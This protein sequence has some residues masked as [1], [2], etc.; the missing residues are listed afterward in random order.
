MSTVFY[1]GMGIDIITPLVCV[2][3]VNKIVATGPL[4]H[5]R[6]KKRT[7]DKSINFICNLIITGNNEFYEGRDVDED[8]FIEFL[9]EEAE[10]MKKYN[11]KKKS[12]VSF[13]IQICRKISNTILLL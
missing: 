8:H 3:N 13:T 10:I 12:I 1:P 5:D 7:L 6:F 11:F 4:P 9:I 2:P